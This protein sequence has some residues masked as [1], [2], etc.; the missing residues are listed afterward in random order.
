MSRAMD[1]TWLV[2]KKELLPI[3]RSLLLVLTILLSSVSLG[4]Q[5][6]P[7]AKNVILLIGDGLG[8]AQTAFGLHYANMVEGRKLHL[9]ALM[10]DGNTGY[11]MPIPYLSTVIDSAAAASQLA[12]G[13][14]ARN[15]TLSLSPD[16][17]VVETVLEAAKRRGLATG[18]VSNMRLSHATP[19]AFAAHQISRYNP[20]P[21]IMDDVLTGYDVDVLLGGGARALV[22]SGRRV[23]E[24]LPG[25][26]DKLDGDSNRKDEV[27]RIAEAKAKGYV[28][29]SD[30]TGLAEALP[31]AD[32]LLG[33]FAASHLPYVLDTRAMGLESVPSLKDMTQAALDVLSRTGNGF[34]LMVEGGRIDYAGHDNDAGTMLHEILDF[35]EALGAV[36]DFEARHPDTLVIVT[37]DHGTGGFSFSYGDFNGRPPGWELPSGLGYAPHHS[38]PTR[39]QLVALGRQ[40]ASYLYILDE[41]KGSPESLVEEV[42]AHTGFEMTIEEARKALVRDADG[43][44]WIEDFSQFYQDQAS[45]PACLL[46]RR[47]ARHTFVV[48]ATGGHTMEPILTFG[49]GPGAEML[50]GVYENTHVYDVAMKVLQHYSGGC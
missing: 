41:A 28:V 29:V 14:K 24:F 30:R 27:N 22:P 47:L 46:G 12:T 49:R 36:L 3:M 18:L 26:V 7:H 21:A 32:K 33:L 20:E 19:A 34:F 43:K 44:A 25:I 9:E 16:G 42:R 10:D 40:S 13:R 8:A 15:E 37:A 4:A 6:A 50:R 5:E 2:F 48:W 11:S 31:K 38:Y 17:Y 39:E 23:S 35:D 45:N 1:V